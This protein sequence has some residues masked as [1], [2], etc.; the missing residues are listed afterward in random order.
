MTES[1]NHPDKRRFYTKS[2][3]LASRKSIKVAEIQLIACFNVKE[4]FLRLRPNPSPVCQM[5]ESFFSSYKTQ[6]FS[7]FK[8]RLLLF[9][10][11]T[12]FSTKYGQIL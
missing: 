11:T 7:F 1:G 10:F 9:S 6:C 8:T 5:T 12:K 2:A 4:K 3:A